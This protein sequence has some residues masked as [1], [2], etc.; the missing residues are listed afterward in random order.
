MTQIDTV[1]LESLS[2]NKQIKISLLG[3]SQ[4]TPREDQSFRPWLVTN[5]HC[6]LEGFEKVF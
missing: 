6:Q 2:L 1:V 5:Q 4:N 3:K